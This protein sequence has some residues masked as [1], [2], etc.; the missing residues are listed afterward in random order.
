MS[1]VIPSRNP[2]LD[3]LRSLCLFFVIIQ[4]SF[5]FTD[6]FY[7]KFRMFWVISHSALDLFFTLSGFLIG[8]IIEKK[9]RESGSLHLRDIFKFYKRRWFK[10]I[11]MYCFTILICLILSNLGLYYAKDF[12]WKFVFFLQNLSR[13]DFNF[14]P[15]TYSL[16][17]EE[18]FYIFFPLGILLL[19]KLFPKS[20]KN[21][22][23]IVIATWITIGFVARLIVH[24]SGIQD[25]DTEVRKV[26]ITRLDA[27]IYGVL[28]YF[29]QLHFSK[30]LKNNRIKLLLIACT[31]YLVCTYILAKK[32]SLFF[33]NVVYYSLVPFITMFVLPFF[34]HLR[35]DKHLENGFTFISLA[36]YSIYIIH[37]PLLYVILGLIKPTSGYESLLYLIGVIFLVIFIGSLFYKTI[38]KP[39]M[40]LRD[41]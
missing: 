37:L 31:L 36:S 33:N 24:F 22:I 28:Y 12:S 1:T 38:E 11:P 41:K 35:L 16:T 7:P 34:V 4:H 40:Y 27:T 19:L 15:H 13:A 6:A 10:T 21:P 30:F 26:I 25:W 9:Y 3:I 29:I 32:Y 17:I 20:K 5:M 2:G 8:G 14:L 39:I 23:V 18:W